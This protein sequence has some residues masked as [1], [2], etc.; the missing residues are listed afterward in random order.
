MSRYFVSLGI[1]S[2]FVV[3]ACSSGE[4]SDVTSTA[5]SSGT[6]GAGAGGHGGQGGTGGGS[7][8]PIESA[9][10][11]LVKQDKECGSGQK[12]DYAACVGSE[13]CFK[14]LYRDDA[15]APLLACYAASSC[16]SGPCRIE[17]AATLDFTQAS[18]AHNQRC[19]QFEIDCPSTSVKTDLCHQI[20][21]SDAYWKVF[22]DALFT[23]IAPCFDQPC[24]QLDVC[25]D[26]V[27]AMLLASCGGDLHGL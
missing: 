7:A 5:S 26:K 16:T 8:S 23:A 21:S 11:G 15:E 12:V 3:S 13:T 24:D 19:K 18:T 14:S 9:C 6:T 1:A 20:N 17:V 2:L 25:I 4:S 10:A 27:A 22:D